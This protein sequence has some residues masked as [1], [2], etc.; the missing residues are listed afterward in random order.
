MFCLWNI[1]AGRSAAVIHATRILSNAGSDLLDS[2]GERPV[3][4]LN[5]EE[6]TGQTFAQDDRKSG[7]I[8]QKGVKLGS[9][10]Q[11]SRASLNI[12]PGER[13]VSSSSIDFLSVSSIGL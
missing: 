10:E 6:E 7:A 2:P 5:Q 12:V 9:T 8:R 11:E 4:R 3:G 1:P 13:M